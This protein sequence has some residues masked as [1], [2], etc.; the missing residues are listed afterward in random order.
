MTDEKGAAGILSV[1]MAVPDRV[2]TN[3]DLEK[4][5]ETSDEWITTRTGIKERRVANP[6]TATSDLAAEA[7]RFA[8]KEA[9]L[10][11]HEI[12]LIILATAT[13][14]YPFP[15][16]ACT[17]QELLD[18]ENAAAFDISAACSGFLYG[19]TI[20]RGMIESGDYRYI[21]L[22]GAET[23]TKICDFT[24]R[25]TCVLFGDGAGAVVLGRVPPG[26]G[27]LSSYLKS[28][29]R[30]T[31]I[32][33]MP[34]GGSRRPATRNTIDNRLHYIKMMGNELFKYATRAMEEA[35]L[36]VIR[37]AGIQADDVD[38]F[39]PHQ[40]NIR[41]IDATAKRLKLPKEKVFINIDRYGN[42]SAASIPIALKEAR[43]QGR[44]TEG[45]TVLLVAAGGGVTWASVLLRL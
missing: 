11:N 3:Y 25:S 2:M 28:D 17:V 15:A 36:E 16:A 27:I 9:G 45:S 14:D 44:V 24:D 43:E 4:I 40:A 10:T 29:G 31:R 7:S 38:L 39:I 30:L 23:L 37:R 6:R 19:M 1:G 41:I 20:A 5:V 34:A 33:N 12:E 26:R 18:A 22:I 21:L 35:A 32:L 8:L 13:P 42:T